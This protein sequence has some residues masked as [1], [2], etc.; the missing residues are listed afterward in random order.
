MI[1]ENQ[2]MK[3]KSADWNPLALPSRPEYKYEIARVVTRDFN[4]WWQRLE[5]R[6]GSLHGIPMGA[7][8]CV[9]RRG[10]GPH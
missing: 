6:K 3:R 4:S 2:A 9:R 10:G 7:P 8:S 5:I 1:L